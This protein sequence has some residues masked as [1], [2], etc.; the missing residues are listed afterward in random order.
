MI[1]NFINHYLIVERK[2]TDYTIDKWRPN[3]LKTLPPLLHGQSRGI[4]REDIV[5]FRAFQRRHNTKSA[6]GQV[7]AGWASERSN[8]GTIQNRGRAGRCR[9]GIRSLRLS[10][11]ATSE[12]VECRKEKNWFPSPFLYAP[13]VAPLVLVR[14]QNQLIRFVV[15]ALVSVPTSF[16]FLFYFILL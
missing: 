12:Q 6:G 4:N 13:L 11:Q 7:D 5:G 14:L 8:G 1:F 16:W 3:W 15:R 9:Q 10:E 2:T